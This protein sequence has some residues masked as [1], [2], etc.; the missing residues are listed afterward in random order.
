MCTNCGMEESEEG[1]LSC[2]N[3]DCST[4]VHLE[5]AKPPAKSLKNKKWKCF[6]CVNAENRLER[7]KRRRLEKGLL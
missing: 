2:M 3:E 7:A 6:K 5:C 1:L 4:Q